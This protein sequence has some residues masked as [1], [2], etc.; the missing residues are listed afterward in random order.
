MIIHPP[1]A[2][3]EF[4]PEFDRQLREYV[5]TTVN[6]APQLVEAV[7]YSVLAPGKRIRP[8]LVVR[9]CELSGGWR[10][11]AWPVA[12]AIECIHAFSLVHDDLPAMD[13]D[14]VRRGKPTTH[15][16]FGEAMAILAGDALFSLAFELVG[17]HLPRHSR[18]G[19]IVR[20]LAESTGWAGMIGGQASDISGESSPPNL[21]LTRAIHERKTA[22]LIACACRLGGMVA[23]ADASTIERLGR[24]GHH[25]GL[26]F[27]IADDLLDVRAS[28][29]QLGK[30]TQKDIHA[31]KQTYPRCVG[32]EASRQAAHDE[33]RKAI[34]AL[35]A[36]GEAAADL[37]Q[38]AEYVVS[39]DY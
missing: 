38:L 12:A 35:S 15:K 27:Q 4:V 1:A 25:L 28:A 9:C 20:E 24:F 7:K 18:L 34:D 22:R 33:L 29:D 13:N 10:D 14:D 17:S 16:Q 26:A 32:V 39:R 8:Y 11:H 3:R 21:V 19:E 37:R 23:I 5:W 6:D 30:A 36:F 31:G 2:L